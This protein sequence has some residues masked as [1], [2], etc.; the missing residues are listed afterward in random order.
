MQVKS[1]MILLALGAVTAGCASFA[2]EDNQAYS[3]GWRPGTVTSIGSGPEYL[4]KLAAPCADKKDATRFAMVRYTGNS[5]LR[6]RA[7]PVQADSDLAVGSR[8][9]INIASCTLTPM[10]VEK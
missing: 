8:V 10:P 7:Y 9:R 4:D 2:R 1:L 6:W 5:H 3:D